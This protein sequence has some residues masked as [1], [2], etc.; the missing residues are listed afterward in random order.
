MPAALAA[1]VRDVALD[2]G[3]QLELVVRV[4][5]QFQVDHAQVAAIVEQPGLVEDVGDAAAHAGREVDPGGPEHR[6]APA[7]HVLAAV[8]ADALDH[9]RHPAVAD[10]ETLAGPAADVDLARGGSVERHVADDDVVGRVEIGARLRLDHD[11]AARQALAQVVVGLAFEHEG[12]AR[13]GE[14][15]RS[16]DRPSPGSAG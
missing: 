5:D 14:S 1:R 9:G 12:H 3:L 8:V 15:G 16:S 10:G 6:H 13:R 11:L 4:G 7:G 2:H